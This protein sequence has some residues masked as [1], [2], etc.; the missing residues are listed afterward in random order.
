ML[1]RILKLLRPHWLL[2]LCSL[3]LNTLAVFFTLLV[4]IEIGMGVDQVVGKDCVDFDLLFGHILRIVLYIALTA[5]CQWTQQQCSNAAAYRIVKKLRSDAYAHLHVLPLSS[6][7]R[8]PSGDTISRV[9]TD[10][11]QLSDGLL[12][13]FN[14]LFTGIL[15]II[16]TIWFLLSIRANLALIVIILTPVSLFIARFIANRSYSHFQSQAA[17]RGSMTGLINESLGNLK[18]VQAFCHEKKDEEEFEKRNTR[19]SESSLLATFYSSLTNPVTRFVNALIYGGVA[20]AGC[21]LCMISPAGLVLT[22]GELTSF[23]AYVRQYSQPFNDITGVVTEFQNSMASAARVFALLDA[24]PESPDPEDPADPGTVRGQVDL[25]HVSFSYLPEKPLIEDLNLSVS[26][27]LRVAIVGP[28]GCGKT[29][30]INLLMRFYDVNKGS[31]LLDG[32]DIRNMTRGSL[33]KNYGMV[34]QETWLREGTIRENI[35]YGAPDASDTQV[36]KAARAAYA[37]SF[38]DRM[39]EGYDTDIG[40]RG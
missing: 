33:R 25:E 28:T 29:T 39:P 37:H 30:L 27:G 18:L 10:I 6:L 20:I 3:L 34:L 22:I 31:I 40:Q 19:F 26:P 12:L 1:G 13:G 11:D 23:L 5:V 2:F 21:L 38:I 16:G 17:A 24:E 4:P 14:Q 15:T 32:T 8:H 9:I 35:T 36:E 7:D